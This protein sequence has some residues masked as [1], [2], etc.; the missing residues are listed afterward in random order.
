MTFFSKGKC[1]F[2]HSFELELNNLEVDYDTQYVGL[3]KQILEHLFA[4]SVV[5]DQ[6]NKPVLRF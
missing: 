3:A 4:A 2:V 1:A 6:M 5:E